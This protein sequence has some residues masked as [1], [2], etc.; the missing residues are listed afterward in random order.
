MRQRVQNLTHWSILDGRESQQLPAESQI[1]STVR[2]TAWRRPD[3]MRR[4]HL[5]C[6]HG[7]TSSEG[8]SYAISDSSDDLV[9]PAPHRLPTRRWPED[10]H[11][12]PTCQIGLRWLVRT[13]ARKNSL[14]ACLPG[15]SRSRPVCSRYRMDQ[16]NNRVDAEGY[17][18]D[19]T[20]AA[21]RPKPIRASRQATSA[22]WNCGTNTATATTRG[23]TASNNGQPGHAS[24]P[25]VGKAYRLFSITMG[26]LSRGLANV[27]A[28]ARLTS[29]R[30]GG[31][32]RGQSARGWAS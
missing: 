24:F 17:A 7:L 15:I 3:D 11:G 30:A 26:P 9:E 13:S 23:A 16:Y 4:A 22:R 18:V 12:C 27:A 28:K 14:I 8:A 19:S 21:C 20:G 31:C 1:D 10:V 6:V 2:K 32:R 25:L 5:P 29:V